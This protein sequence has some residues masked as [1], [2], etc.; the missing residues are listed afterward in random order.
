MAKPK[1]TAIRKATNQHVNRTCIFCNEAPGKYRYSPSLSFH[2]RIEVNAGVYICD[3][4]WDDLEDLHGPFV[5]K[6]K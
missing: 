3:P 5:E 6:P 4:C 2:L 1:G